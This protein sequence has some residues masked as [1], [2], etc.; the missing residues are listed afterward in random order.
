M[1]FSDNPIVVR[2]MVVLW[3]A[4]SALVIL[5]KMIGAFVPGLADVAGAMV[6]L[7]AHGEREVSGASVVLLALDWWAA[8]FLGF[9]FGGFY[10]EATIPFALFAFS[11]VALRI[12][13]AHPER[14]SLMALCESLH[15]VLVS[16]GG[17]VSWMGFAHLYLSV[18]RQKPGS[19]QVRVS[20]PPPLITLFLGAGALVCLAVTPSAW[21]LAKSSRPGVWLSDMAS[22]VWRKHRST[23]AVRSAVAAARS[24]VLWGKLVTLRGRVGEPDAMLREAVKAGRTWVVRSLIRDYGAVAD[25]PSSS[26]ARPLHIAASKGLTQLCRVLI[27]EFGCAVQASDAPLALPG[28]L[29]YACKNG[30]ADT[31]RALAKE[32][33][34]S[35]DDAGKG[36]DALSVACR[37]KHIEVVRVLLKELAVE[38]TPRSLA[39]AKHWPEVLA[40]LISLGDPEDRCVGVSV[41]FKAVLARSSEALAHIIRVPAQAA[42]A[43]A[44]WLFPCGAENLTPL[45]VA[46]LTGEADL[47]SLIASCPG[48]KS[49][50]TLRGKSSGLAPLAMAAWG[51]HERVVEAVV[52]LH[53]AA[54]VEP[55]WETALRVAVR[56]GRRGVTALLLDRLASARELS[57]AGST[58]VAEMRVSLAVDARQRGYEGLARAL[59]DVRQPVHP[60]DPDAK[61]PVDEDGPSEYLC[62]ISRCLLKDPVVTADGNTYELQLISEWFRDQKQDTSPSTNLRLPTKTLVPNHALAS[63]IRHWALHG[64]HDQAGE[65]PAHI[66]KCPISDAT[67][68][69]P[70]IL[71]DGFTYEKA[72]AE[73][74]LSQRGCIS[75]V[76]GAPL[77][78]PWMA[79][80][81]AIRGLL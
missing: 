49:F 4:Y 51:G 12:C 55:D 20:P 44:T 25:L 27:S 61:A 81:F 76:T 73:E 9:F 36:K 3:V 13:L 57:H 17:C 15:F 40:L 70:V 68:R 79:P 69:D 28:P 5:G 14:P 7:S 10:R 8:F 71:A 34:A 31:V 46:C 65:G 78:G 63:L 50:L 56:Q 22:R 37:N 33:R 19:R 21:R 60:R 43:P 77:P 58:A 53:E 80:N 67:I 26:G 47:F 38:V 23:W 66:L 16:A 24:L 62:P 35:V 2:S 18:E 72:S 64:V 41:A 6:P 74:H 39:S 11:W 45:H 42:G 32:F 59:E 29:Y 48:A 54:E 75:P 52:A 30:H 1:Y